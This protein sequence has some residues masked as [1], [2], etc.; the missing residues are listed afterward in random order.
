MQASLYILAVFIGFLMLPMQ[1]F[2]LSSDKDQ[3]INIEADQL[4]IDDSKHISIYR[5]NV[6]MRQGSLHI[7]ANRI[8][9]FFTEDNDLI[10]LEIQGKPA[11]F[12]QLNDKQ[13]PMQGSALNMVY[14]ENE[15]L[16]K[17][18]GQA[19]FQSNEDTIESE[20]ITINTE[21]NALEAGNGEKKGRVR[22]LIQPQNN[23]RK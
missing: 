19:R 22:M 12:N 11:T 4:E 2:A 10:R 23:N 21:S 6:D 8:D 13:E 7:R 9:F 17:L 14:F 16:L 18:N 20:T 5:G 3:P 1:L 15:S